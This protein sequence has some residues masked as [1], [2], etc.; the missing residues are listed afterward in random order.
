MMGGLWRNLGGGIRSKFL[1]LRRDSSVPEWPYFVMGAADPAAPAGLRAYADVAE[2]EGM[3]PQYVADV[4]ATAD[5][6]EAWREENHTGDPDAPQHRLDDPEV[7]ARMLE[8]V[9]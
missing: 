7:A 4:R 5:R 1:V 2:Q 6:F 3:D 9:V 8:V